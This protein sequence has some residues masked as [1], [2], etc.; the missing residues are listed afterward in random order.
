MKKFV[1]IT[2]LSLLTG[3]SPK[4]RDFGNG[5][6]AGS[7]SAS[8]GG[9]GGGSNS[10]SSSQGSGG[11]GGSG[12]SGGCV[13]AVSDCP[14]PRG[15]CVEAVCREGR[16][17]ELPLQEGTPCR[18]SGSAACDAAGV[19]VECAG[20]TTCGMCPAPGCPTTCGSA[21]EAATPRSC[22]PGA[23]SDCGS[24]EGSCCDN[25][26][27]RCGN[28]LRSYDGVAYNNTSHPAAVSDFRLDRYEITV[29]RFREFVNAGR[30]VQANPPMVGVGAHPRVSGT[31]WHLNWNE[32]LADTTAALKA[33]L[34]C[35]PHGISTWTD[36]PGPNE[37][38][39]INCITWY[40]AFAF[41]AWDGGRLPSQA[42]WNYTAAGG[43]E[44]RE[45]PWGSG[46]DGARAVY[47]CTGDGSVADDCTLGDILPVGSRPLGNGR[48]GHSDL[49]GNVWEWIMDWWS[50]ELSL[51]CLDCVF[52]DPDPESERVT[53]G[54]SF[55][56]PERDLR[57]ALR[58]KSTPMD[59][60]NNIGARCA[61]DP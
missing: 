58:D 15:A 12:G 35:D 21:D 24:G 29:G 14:P 30:G 2:A 13:D 34:R 11:D 42:E 43:D 39:P 18:E 59:R 48:W 49:A 36:E 3:C 16:C 27:V 8:S 26:L 33:A 54:G 20:G 56:A 10:S 6:V 32:N 1:L 19:C 7:G 61:R 55:R 53:L 52:T 9:G 4:D 45:Y 23:P 38:L 44:Q 51:P 31:G 22:A 40:E 17:E 46:I 25:R 28:Y 41:C 60:V 50:E 37:A 47:D 5:D 57:A